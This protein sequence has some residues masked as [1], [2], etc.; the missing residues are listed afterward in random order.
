M[1]N[2]RKKTSLSRSKDGIKRGNL[3][4]ILSP[5]KHLG[6]KKKKEKEKEKEIAKNTTVPP[7]LVKSNTDTACLRTNPRQRKKVS[8]ER[9][10]A[11]SSLKCRNSEWPSPEDEIQK[12][13]IE[14][15]RQLPRTYSSTIRLVEF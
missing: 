9:L 3:S 13:T 15:I 4:A 6:Q 7:K 10:D 14:S 2:K 1:E 11:E 8:S 5:R 12:D